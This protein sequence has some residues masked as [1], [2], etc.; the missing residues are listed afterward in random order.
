MNVLWTAG[1]SLQGVTR[2]W[3]ETCGVVLLPGQVTAAMRA[4]TAPPMQ[5]NPPCRAESRCSSCI[6]K[7]LPAPQPC[8]QAVGVCFLAFVITAGWSY[9]A[10]GLG[11]AFCNRMKS[12][13][14][15]L[16]GFSDEPRVSEQWG[17][18][19]TFP[20]V[21]IL[22]Q[23]QSISYSILFN[24]KRFMSSKLCWGGHLS[25]H[26]PCTSFALALGLTH[27]SG[28]SEEQTHWL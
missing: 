10:L 17:T 25:W 12:L 8:T 6:W 7:G 22:L 14:S 28:Y 11:N 16:R 20:G 26:L 9:L 23:T 18:E 4:H 5:V 15:L 13:Q 1:R 19:H 21:L 27:S 3:S 24:L 2:V